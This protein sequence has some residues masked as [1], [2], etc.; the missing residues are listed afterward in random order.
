[1]KKQFLNFRNTLL[2]F[3]LIPLTSALIILSILCINISTNNIEKNIK[4]ELSL[5]S[6]SLKEYYIYDLIENVDL[7]DGFCEYNTEYIDKMCQQTGIDFTLFKEDTRF[8]TSIL[9]SSGQR[10]EG[11]KA[12]A[13]VYAKVKAGEEYFSDDVKI[14]GV[15]Y[16]V[17]YVPL[18]DGNNFY[19]MAFSG[20]PCTDIKKAERTMALSVLISGIAMEII[21]VI[22]ALLISVKISSPLKGLSEKIQSLSLGDTNIEVTEKANIAETKVL[23]ESVKKLAEVLRS[24]ITKIRSE[25]DNLKVAVESTA[26]LSKE[27]AFS[28]SQISG[29]MMGLAQTTETMAENVQDINTN[30][31]QMGDLVENA[32]S[33]TNNLAESSEKM[34]L[35]NNEAEDCINNMTESSKR[36]LEAIEKVTELINITNDSIQKINEMTNIITNI[37]TQTNLLALNASIEAARAGEAGKGFS[38]V[39]EEIKNL[40]EQS[41]QSAEEIKGVVK[42]I[43]FQSEECVNESN[44]VKVIVNEQ[45]SLLETTLTKFDALE[46]EITA[47]VTEISS[48]SAITTELSE[49]KNTLL[50]AVSDLSAISEETAATNEEVTASLESISQNIDKISADGEDMNNMAISLEDA[51]AYFK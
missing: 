6:H 14:N 13:E 32:V 42:A 36:S 19:G 5:A 25:A 10:I 47:S 35:A 20:K 27:S 21:F 31:I 15:D 51:I 12:S 7:K 28:T 26:N 41:K 2:M 29:S 39:A 33:S 22:I 24:S 30:T 38:V 46:E 43:S 50:G 49:I 16:Y 40:A 3:A 45:K 34:T 4:E 23:I 9:D 48:I 18:K 11:T 44:E 8:M 17:Y 37:A 1:M